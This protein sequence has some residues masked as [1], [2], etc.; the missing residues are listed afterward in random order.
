[1]LTRLARWCVHRRN[2]VLVAWLGLLIALG[3]ALGLLGNAFSDNSTLPASDSATAYTLLGR[4]G[5]HAA[6]G[7]S[8]TIVW[9]TDSGSVTGATVRDEINPA[10]A[11]IARLDGIVSVTSP[12]TVS[13]SAQVS[14]D[15]HTAYATVLFDS[16]KHADD[17]KSL[18]EDAAQRGLTVE[19][20]GKAFTDQVPSETGEII[21]VL[22]ALAVLLLVFRSIWAAALPII[23]GVAGVGLSSVTV[24]LLSHVITMSSIVTSMSA[25]IGLG[26]GIDYALFI[27][28]R[29]RKALRAGDDI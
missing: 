18:A 10:L 28:N 29:Q 2:Y 3:A 20:G 16:T 22:A 7:T 5:S 13:G 12:Y 4:A 15:G 1:M 23:T 14:A 26:V 19:T 27:V 24:M 6:S 25:L 17:A 21:G 8:G 9:H 11:K